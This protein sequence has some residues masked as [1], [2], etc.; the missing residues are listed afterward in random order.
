MFEFRA[1]REELSAPRVVAPAL[2]RELRQLALSRRLLQYNVRTQTLCLLTGL[3]AHRISAWRR[4][5]Q[6][7]SEPRH[8][9]PPPTSFVALLRSPRF[10]SEL[11]CL[12]VLLDY[13]DALPTRQECREPSWTLPRAE[14]LCDAFDFYRTLVLRSQVSFEQL[15]LLAKGLGNPDCLRRRYCECCRGVMVVDPGALPRTRCDA[16]V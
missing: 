10:R 2:E 6:L 14:R 7:S 3:T 5:W 9:G 15:L 16:C 4:R 12:A 11:A 8:R 13:F 1:P